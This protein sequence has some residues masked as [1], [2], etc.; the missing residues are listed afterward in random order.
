MHIN[1]LNHYAM[2]SH[3]TVF[4]EES[5]TA[6]E[7]AGRTAHKVNEAVCAVNKLHDRVE[8]IFSAELEKHVDKWLTEHPE[9]TTTIQDGEIT[10][11]KLHDSL[12][13]ASLNDFVIPQM[14]GA[15][16]DGVHDDTEAFRQLN[17]KRAYIP[18]GTY[19]I[20]SV[21]YGANTIILGAGMG[22]TIL[23]QIGSDDVDM[24]VFK[25]ADRA[26]L[27][28]ITL[29][30]RDWDSR[31]KSS[32][33]YTGLL[34]IY[35][36][37]DQKEMTWAN[38]CVFEHIHIWRS[39]HSGLVLVGKQTN[40]GMSNTHWNWVHQFN[41][42]RIESCN[43]WC[44][45]DETTDNRFDNFYLNEGGLGNL[46][47]QYAGNNLYSNFKLDQPY[48]AGFHGDPD[49]WDTGALI[50]CKNSGALRMLNFDVQSSYYHGMKMES[51][52]VMH[53]DGL[54]SNIGYQSPECEPACMKLYNTHNSTFNVTQS[55]GGEFTK[56]MAYINSNCSNVQVQV[57]ENIPLP[58]VNKGTNCAII[59][60]YDLPLLFNKVLTE[61]NTINNLLSDPVPGSNG[62]NNWALVGATLDGN[63]KVSGTYSFKINSGASATGQVA[64]T[65][66]NAKVGH[67]YLCVATFRTEV[68]S[69]VY[70][71]GYATP[72]LLITQNSHEVAYLDGLRKN[73]GNS[74]GLSVAC[75]AFVS[76]SDAFNVNILNYQ[77]NGTFYVGNMYVIDL[78]ENKLFMNTNTYTNAIVDQ[79]KENPLEVK[80]TM[81]ETLAYTE[82]METLRYLLMKQEG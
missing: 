62:G 11:D 1:P 70:E 46:L 38:Y 43:A 77:N 74:V 58:S 73:A 29:Q 37:P 63:A 52:S 2:E 16:G 33:P 55:W 42:L 41:D 10:A 34:K 59:K 47:I 4:D 57:Q 35:T 15:V 40:S 12:K 53:F 66:T 14:Y 78:T 72:Y 45:I 48:G 17:G 30:G 13:M 79:F 21:E 9:I 65:V 44:M 20:S 51:C 7:L 36:T 6:L 61:E 50:V 67:K 75:C 60:A 69:T 54:F 26:G 68:P 24:V 82:I 56:Y 8:Q 71:A 28:N 32:A 76:E 5:L 3:P 19:R 39:M 64:Q 80:S 31:I 25:N 27:S 22:N 81:T 23:R 18:K 49:G